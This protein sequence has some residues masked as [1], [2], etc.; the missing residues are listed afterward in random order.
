MVWEKQLC[1]IYDFFFQVALCDSLWMIHLVKYMYFYFT[2]KYCF[3]NKQWF[4]IL[5]VTFTCQVLKLNECNTFLLKF[6]LLKLKFTL[7][8]NYKGHTFIINEECQ[9]NLQLYQSEDKIWF[10]FSFFIFPG[11]RFFPKFSLN[12]ALSENIEDCHYNSTEQ[13]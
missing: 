9:T 12:F 6:V 13:W 10:T 2:P 11:S 3:L 1:L 8:L 5:V 7:M 4:K